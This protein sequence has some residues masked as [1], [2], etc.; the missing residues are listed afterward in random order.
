MPDLPDNV[1]SV[2]DE[3]IEYRDWGARF[4]ELAVTE[5]RVLAG[6]NAMAGQAI[7]V[8]PMGVGPGRVAKVT[9]K[10]QIG[11]ATG[12][13]VSTDPVRYEA[14]LPVTIHFKLDLGVDVHRF[15]A[16]IEIPLRLTARARDD[17]A[18]VIE[19]EPP[20]S[21]DITVDLK[22]HGLRASLTQRAANVEGE[23]RR[24]VAKYVG[25][26]IGKPKVQAARVIDVATAIN[27]AAGSVVPKANDPER[28]ADA[29]QAL[30]EELREADDLF[31]GEGS[32]PAPGD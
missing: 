5:E 27:R 14:R 12:R 29:S 32:G 15:D 8:G 30:A 3:L 2:T 26:E 31:I 20:R 19:I 17:L 11:T 1:R 4:F 28:G 9:A 6:V 16:D 13:R 21:S 10:G 7:D 24:F 25:R 22:A 23:L 18:I